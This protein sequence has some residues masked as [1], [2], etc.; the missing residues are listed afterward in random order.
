MSSYLQLHI[1]LAQM[2]PLELVQLLVTEHNHLPWF[3]LFP[4]ERLLINCFCIPRSG[5]FSA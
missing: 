5:F 2:P 4:H 1:T 3:F